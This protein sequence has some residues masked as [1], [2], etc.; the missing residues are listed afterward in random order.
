[1]TLTYSLNSTIPAFALNKQNVRKSRLLDYI[2]M[3]EDELKQTS[4]VER[5]VNLANRFESNLTITSLSSAPSIDVEKLKTNLAQ[6]IKKREKLLSSWFLSFRPN[7]MKEIQN[8]DKVLD[9][10]EYQIISL[11]KDNREKEIADIEKFIAENNK[12][13]QK[14]NS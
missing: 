1:M 9:N 3:I 11:Q 2:E 12:I 10:I 8:I 6:Q 13:I 5:Q 4:M 14:Y 7:K